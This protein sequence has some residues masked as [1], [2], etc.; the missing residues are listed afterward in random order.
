MSITSITIGAIV[1][2]AAEDV[3]ARAESTAPK[4][5]LP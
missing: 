4:E 1:A 5:V 2:I 3:L